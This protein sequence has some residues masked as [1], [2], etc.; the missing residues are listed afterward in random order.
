M[1]N[2]LNGE[3]ALAEELVNY[4]CRVKKGEKVLITY[5]DAPN[6]FIELLIEEIT[7]V[8]AIPLVFR[9]DKKIKR[10]LLLNSSKEMFEY[11]KD[12][13]SPIMQTADAVILIGGSMNDFEL[14][15]VPSKTLSDYSR[16]YVEPVHFKIRCSKKWVL[17]RYPTPSFS[18]SSH[19]S[20]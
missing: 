16:I 18:Q 10:R 19:M 2:K 1:Y 12:I 13:V 4:S 6:T 3:H 20:T 8:G 17:L 5:S 14:S 15:D 9:L 7:K 11:Y